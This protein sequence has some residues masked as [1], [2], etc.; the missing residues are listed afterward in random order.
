M[1]GQ[2]HI[3]GPQSPTSNIEDVLKI[4]CPPGPIAI[5][6]AGWRYDE[7]DISAL[8][9]AIDR[10][11][12]HLPLY[13][14]F[15][16]LGGMEPELSGLHR[17]RRR[18]ILAYK[19]VY[20]LQLQSA[21]ES[22]ESIRKLHRKQPSLY[23]QDEENACRIIQNLDQQCLDRLEEIRSDFTAIEQPWLHETAL[24]LYEEIAFTLSRCKAV[25]ITGGHVAILRNRLKF[26][27]LQNLLHEFLDDGNQI[28]AW[29]AGAMA[30]S[31]RIVLY[32]DDP[33]WEKGYPEIMDSGLGLLN[34]VIFFPHASS[35][36]DLSDPN[37]IERLS[38][39]FAPDTCIC[40]ENGAHLVFT[41]MGL[42]DLSAKRS[43]FRLSLEGT[44]LALENL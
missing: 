35:R 21:L 41:N 44:K 39:R 14:W 11:I 30:L 40:L 17:M 32:H 31:H 7:D 15:D 5:I 16:E 4:H 8:T 13:E 22:W 29:S 33:P 19:K 27:G 25:I 3:L 28:Y 2:I 26:F 10:E 36:L 12:Y 24:P 37:R 34:R 23:E 18:R 38:R 20:H 6:S 1:F 9:Q 43:A 42:E